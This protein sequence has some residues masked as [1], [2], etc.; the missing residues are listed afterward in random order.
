MHFSIRRKALAAATLASFTC[1]FQ[2]AN[3]E[4]S[5]AAT[6]ILGMDFVNA[7]GVN[8]HIVYTDSQYAN[9]AQTVAALSCLGIRLIRDASPNPLN[10][11]QGSYAV[12][13]KAGV[14]MVLFNGGD[15]PG[16]TQPPPMSVGSIAA[17][18][19]AYP[20]S[21]HA[22]EG[23]NEVN[24]GGVSYGGVIGTPGAQAFQSALYADTRAAPQLANIPVY[25]LV[26]Y[27]DAQGQAD[28]ANF[29]SYPNVNQSC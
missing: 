16:G 2:L 8:T 22:V 12:V 18:A 9:N 10:Q 7:L 29:H 21:I 14:R 5:S 4:R 27:P 11:G 24:N 25:N 20:G 15:A 1:V 19:Q 3:P 26:D 17:L 13:A 6:A 23:P 28:Y